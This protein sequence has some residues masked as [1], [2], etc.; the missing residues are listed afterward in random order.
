MLP[1]NTN[2]NM[3]A[4]TIPRPLSHGPYML[5]SKTTR[6]TGRS[7]PYYKYDAKRRYCSTEVLLLLLH[8]DL[9]GTC[10]SSCRC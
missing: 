3:K 5:T 1:A 8:V 10:R 2:Y 4:N 6:C 7:T 9:L